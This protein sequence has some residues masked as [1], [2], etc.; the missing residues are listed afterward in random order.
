MHYWAARPFHEIFLQDSQ[1]SVFIR[2]LQE[3][4]R[5]ALTAKLSRRGIAVPRGLASVPFPFREAV[6]VSGLYVFHCMTSQ[7]NSTVMP[8]LVLAQ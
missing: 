1:R 7:S 3:A 6:L 2:M 5:H 8:A 4:A